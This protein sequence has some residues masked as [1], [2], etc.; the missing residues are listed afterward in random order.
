MDTFTG[1][2]VP[3]EQLRPQ[4][5]QERPS[6]SSRKGEGFHI[7]YV[8]RANGQATFVKSSKNPD[9]VMWYI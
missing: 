1:E 3:R 2:F 8:A 5:R 9:L 4:A 6:E 7:K